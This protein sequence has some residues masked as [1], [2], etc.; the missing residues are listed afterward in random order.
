MPYMLSST[1]VAPH[2]KDDHSL[3]DI[4]YKMEAS[5]LKAKNTAL[6]KFYASFQL[7]DC[8]IRTLD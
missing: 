7:K 2:E 3:N 1:V 6:Y 5:Y 4:S 8:L